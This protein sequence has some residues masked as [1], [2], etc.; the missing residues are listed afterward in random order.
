MFGPYYSKNDFDLYLGD[1]LDVLSNL[2]ENSVDLIFAD[3]PYFLSN[4]GI[5]C[6]SGKIASV[7]KADWDKSKGFEKDL[8][9]GLRDP[10]VTRLK[11][12]LKEQ[13]Y[14]Q[15]NTKV[16]G[17]N[18]QIKFK[19]VRGFQLDKGI[20]SSPED[21]GAGRCGPKTR[22]VINKINDK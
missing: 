5:T 14:F 21:G 11:D 4:G 8:E 18:G 10:E 15:I 7:N 12:F 22:E 9:F 2:D 1:N 16:T 20:I 13:G 17:N 19:E 6:K 3:P